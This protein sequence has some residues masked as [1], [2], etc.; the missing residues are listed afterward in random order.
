M[1][2]VDIKHHVYLLLR[3][4]IIIFPLD[5]DWVCCHLM[6]TSG[7]VAVLW[8]PLHMCLVPS[9]GYGIVCFHLMVKAVCCHLMVT[10]VFSPHALC[11]LFT[12]H[13]Y[14]CV[15]VVMS[16]LLCVLP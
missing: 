15:Y 3:V 2:S 9:H 16:L 6:V 11:S 12:S 1:V 14:Y 4:L 5:S 8:L 13:G 7:F 10:A